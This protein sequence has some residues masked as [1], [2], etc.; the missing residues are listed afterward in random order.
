MQRELLRERFAGAGWEVPRLLEEAGRAGAFYH[1]GRGRAGRRG[2]R[3]HEAIA[4][5]DH[6]PAAR[7]HS[8]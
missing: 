8:G 6:A 3:L 4:L 2:A 5:K 7:E 1:P